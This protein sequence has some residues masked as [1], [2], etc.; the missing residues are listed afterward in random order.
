[1]GHAEDLC[2]GIVIGK[3]RCDVDDGKDEKGREKGAT[4]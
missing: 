4:D 2:V 3:R 1:V